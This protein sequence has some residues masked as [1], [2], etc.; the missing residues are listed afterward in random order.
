MGDGS[1]E[2]SSRDPA[3]FSEVR[4]V[5][6]TDGARP[7]KRL[8]ELEWV[9]GRVYANVYLTSRVVVINPQDGVVQAELDLTPLFRKAR[10]QVQ[11]GVANGIAWDSKA[12]RLFI[13]G[14]NW[15][16]IYEIKVRQ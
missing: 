1:A 13:T 6:V 8:N 7:V 10:D 14:K 2:L 3:D 16:A 11:A 9:E 4:R 12:R 15:P 5:T